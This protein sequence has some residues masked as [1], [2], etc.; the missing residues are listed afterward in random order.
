MTAPTPDRPAAHARDCKEQYAHTA[1]NRKLCTCALRE[2]QRI[3]DLE[4]RV[5]GMPEV[6]GPQLEPEFKLWRKEHF[7]TVELYLHECRKPLSLWGHSMNAEDARWLAAALLAAA[8]EA[9]R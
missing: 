2:R 3:F 1:A 6:G 7:A 5:A 9:E 4:R 8:N